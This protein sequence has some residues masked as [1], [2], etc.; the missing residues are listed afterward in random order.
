MHTMKMKCKSFLVRFYYNK[1]ESHM[2]VLNNEVGKSRFQTTI[3][4]APNDSPWVF[5]DNRSLWM[6]SSPLIVYW[7]YLYPGLCS[8]LYWSFS[9]WSQTV[10]R[11]WW[12]WRADLTQPRSRPPQGRRLCP[13][14]E[15]QSQAGQSYK[16]ETNNIVMVK[17]NSRMKGKLLNN[18]T[19]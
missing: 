5:P 2:G 3:F 11:T 16:W 15:H 14:E 1:T 13:Q 9:W 17:D 10:P 6:L 19:V 8:P 12:G 4:I 7:I 18:L